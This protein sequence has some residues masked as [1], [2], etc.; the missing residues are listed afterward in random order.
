MVRQAI[1]AAGAKVLGPYSQ[2]VM[3]GNLLFL[4]G[5]IPLD[6]ATGKLVEG[7][8]AAQTAQSLKN[9][10]AVLAAAGLTLDSV[11]KTTVYLTDMKD[12]AE[13][14]AE[15]AKHFAAPCPARTTVEV[16][17]LPLGARLEIEAIAS[18]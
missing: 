12:F 9:L 15:Y 4:S 14:N 16:S 8:I 17:A 13:M 2:S 7:D 5:Q 6:G 1:N 10:A 18:K 3:T 11:V